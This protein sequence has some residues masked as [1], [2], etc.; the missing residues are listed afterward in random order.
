MKSGKPLDDQDRLPWLQDLRQEI[1]RQIDSGPGM[2]LAC[3]ALKKVYRDLLCGQNS[4]GVLF[5]YLKCSVETLQRNFAKR[6]HHFMTAQMIESQLA[7]LEEPFF[8]PENG[9]TIQCDQISPSAAVKT[10]CAQ[11]THSD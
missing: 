7:A 1:T 8:P 3:S 4:S 9:F 10:I 11:I 6:S 5:V 2:V